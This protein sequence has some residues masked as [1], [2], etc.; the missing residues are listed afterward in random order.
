VVS[1]L[2]DFHTKFITK[3]NTERYDMSTA[4]EHPY[5]ST[6]NYTDLNITIKVTQTYIINVEIRPAFTQQELWHVVP[7]LT[8]QFPPRHASAHRWFVLFNTW[9]AWRWLSSGSYRRVGRYKPEDSQLP[10]YRRDNLKSYVKSLCMFPC[11]IT[12]TRQIS[13]TFHET[14]NRDALI[15]HKNY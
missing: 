8:C 10:S 11:A 6:V 9:K 2:R 15:K 7:V 13:T 5:I 4:S 1:S 12:H 3:S 14:G